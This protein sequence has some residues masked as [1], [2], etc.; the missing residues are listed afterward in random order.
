MLLIAML[1]GCGPTWEDFRV[2]YAEELCASMEQ[3]HGEADPTCIET[4]TEA[5]ADRVKPDDY[6]PAAAADCLDAVAAYG[7]TCT[8]EDAATRTDLCGAAMYGD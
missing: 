4:Y 3:C 1:V 8:G 7:E 2:A 5:L 6:T